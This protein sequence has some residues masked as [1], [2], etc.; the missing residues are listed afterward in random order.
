MPMQ[1]TGAS[2]R[3]WI[4]RCRRSS[5]TSKWLCAMSTRLERA[6][7]TAVH[8][9]RAAKP[10]PQGTLAA[11]ICLVSKLF[12]NQCWSS[13]VGHTEIIVDHKN[14]VGHQI[15]KKTVSWLNGRSPPFLLANQVWQSIV[16]GEDLELEKE[17]EV[18]FWIYPE[19]QKK[20]QT[21]G[22]TTKGQHHM[23]QTCWPSASHWL[24]VKSVGRM[25][26]TPDQ[27]SHVFQGL[28]TLALPAKLVVAFSSLV[29][30]L[31]ISMLSLCWGWHFH[32][33]SVDK[34]QL[35]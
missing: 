31:Q 25:T 6:G 18:G 32:N 23:V 15:I 27:R 16:H 22:H 19:G 24:P 7:F 12:L 21:V 20:W 1:V 14:M 28:N 26:W 29:V 34:C 2:P 4:T 13:K 10:T 3:S 35:S 30:H 9:S 8:I 17:P 33:R 5:R 11:Y